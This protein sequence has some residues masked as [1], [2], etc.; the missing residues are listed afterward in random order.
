MN[1]IV[2][3]AGMLALLFIAVGIGMSLDTEAQRRESR[4]LAEERRLRALQ[5]GTSGT[6]FCRD[7]PYRFRR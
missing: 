3:V 1:L 4:R 2:A 5:P 6:Y 7:C